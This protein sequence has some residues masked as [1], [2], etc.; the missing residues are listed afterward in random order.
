M[1]TSLT[2]VT[3]AL[4]FALTRVD[5]V[6]AELGLTGS[7]EDDQIDDYI[8]QAS[9][10][11]TGY[12]GRVIA[13]ETVTETFRFTAQEACRWDAIQLVLARYPVT[14]IDSVVAGGTALDEADY[15]VG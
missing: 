12:L 3:P 7:S 15:E 2:V 11:I 6:K 8:W 9:S 13:E 10:A 5:T 1:Q 4:S 14:D